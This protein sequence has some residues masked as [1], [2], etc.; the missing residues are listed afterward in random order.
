MSQKIP[1][2]HS[3][4]LGYFIGKSGILSDN[5]PAIPATSVSCPLNVFIYRPTV[6]RKKKD[7]RSSSLENVRE[8][9][10]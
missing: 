1:E 3:K 8:T 6:D 7:F 10:L 2:Y 4:C 5:I 9:F